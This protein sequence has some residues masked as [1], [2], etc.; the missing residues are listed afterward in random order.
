VGGGGKFSLRTYDHLSKPFPLK[1]IAI[2]SLTIKWP[3][4]P[5]QA[6]S[7]G[8]RQS[9][10]LKMEHQGP[11]PLIALEGLSWY[12]AYQ[13][14]HGWQV[15]SFVYTQ[16]LSYHSKV[17]IQIFE[18]IPYPSPPLPSPEKISSVHLRQFPWCTQLCLHPADCNISLGKQRVVG[19]LLTVH[20]GW[21]LIYTRFGRLYIRRFRSLLE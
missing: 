9:K 21:Y 14:F 8:V 18:W 2:Y 5:W 3:L 20:W 7:S 12:I 4:S 6:K 10:I 1:F 19:G 17:F 16:L 13:C 11:L 15:H